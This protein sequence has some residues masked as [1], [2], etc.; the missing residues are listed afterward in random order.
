MIRSVAEYCQVVYHTLIMDRLDRLEFQCLKNIYENRLS[1]HKM[2]KKAG[3]ERLSGRRS[4]AFDKFAADAANSAAF[5][6]WF[7]WK[8]DRLGGRQC[9]IYKEYFA[10]TDRLKLSPRFVMASSMSLLSH[11]WF[12]SVL[13]SLITI[14]YQIKIVNTC[15]CELLPVT[16]AWILV[17]TSEE[18]T[19]HEKKLPTKIP[20]V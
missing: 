3:I 20:T 4:K 12:I 14:R 5:K 8:V 2:L 10:R 17:K 15:L 16:Y 11:G 6:H 7:P 9:G 19:N 13:L 18:T 1:Y